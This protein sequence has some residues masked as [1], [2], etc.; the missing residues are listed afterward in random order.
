MTLT[1]E[2]SDEKRVKI[3]P[4]DSSVPSKTETATFSMGCFWG[5]D[6][7]FGS[8]PG[9]VRTRVGYA[10]GQTANPTYYNIG[11]HIETIQ[12][13]YDPGVINYEKLLNV[14]LENH[15]PHKPGWLRQYM[16]AIF[17]HNDHQ[18]KFVNGSLKNRSIRTQ[19]S[20]Y[21][22]IMPFSKFYLAEGYHQKYNLKQYPELISDY[23][24]IYSDE[25]DFTHSTSAA[26]VNGYVSG[27]GTL[28][29]FEAEVKSLGLSL[30]ANEKIRD[31]ISRLKDDK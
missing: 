30:S 28:P 12:I 21:T 8:T 7:L 9:V 25:E 6:A 26:K 13:D 24:S 17:H 31:I 18:E 14:F 23:I 2:S 11:D 27:Y 10:G 20:I 15:N 22:E 4:I 3:P 1:K 16:S 29:G 19:R 5:P